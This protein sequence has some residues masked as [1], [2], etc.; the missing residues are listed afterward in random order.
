MPHA[1]SG[2]GLLALQLMVEHVLPTKL[3]ASCEPIA[4]SL[5]ETHVH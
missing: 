5:Q 1:F 2:V 3:A 4:E